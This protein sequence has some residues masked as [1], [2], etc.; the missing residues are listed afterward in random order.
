MKTNYKDFIEFKMNE[1]VKL[2]KVAKKEIVGDYQILI[3][4]SAQMN[5]ILT[6]EVA[7]DDDWWFHVK[8]V[9]GSHVVIKSLIKKEPNFE[10]ELPPKEVVEKAIRL[11]VDNSKAGSGKVEVVYTQ[12]KNV[13]KNDSHNDGQVSVDYRNAIVRTIYSN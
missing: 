9:P 3:G 12:R 13:T 11:A 4:R 5:D 2:S 6:F 1:A 10:G 8:G 7:G